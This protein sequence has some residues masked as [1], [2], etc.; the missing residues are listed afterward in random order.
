MNRAAA[1]PF[2][3]ITDQEIDGMHDT[4]SVDLFAGPHTL[5]GNTG[6]VR[7]LHDVKALLDAS[8]TLRILDVG[9]VGGSTEEPLHLW[10]PLLT[11]YPKFSLVG[12]DVEHIERGEAA[13][14]AR[15]V[16]DRIK[17]VRGS[18]YELAS[19]VPV[20]SFDVV[21]ALQVME[22]VARIDR[23]VAQVAQV[24]RPGGHAFFTID[25]AHWLS[26]Y[27]RRKP[28]RMVK[29]VVKKTLSLLGREHRFSYDL[30]WFDHEVATVS[31]NAGLEVVETRY[32]NQQPL[33][34]LHNHVVSTEQRNALMRQW[35]TLEEFLNDD[36]NTRE[37]SRHLY[38]VLYVHV[39]KPA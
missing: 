16:Q 5:T 19:L 35:Y 13:I 30:P 28:V 7:V 9:C 27:D 37:R 11:V 15:G 33:K 1:D 34:Q 6:K 26:R 12:V 36:P 39:R 21:L 25:S 17:L 24:L 14:R 10:Q 3:A 29:N 20:N 32:Y 18:G 8:P 4:M 38:Q 2:R 23:F 31:R 22:H